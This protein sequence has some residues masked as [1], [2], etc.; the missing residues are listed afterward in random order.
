MTRHFLHC[1][2]LVVLGLLLVQCKASKNHIQSLGTGIS[3]Q[4]LTPHLYVHLSHI[5]LSNGNTFPCNGLIYINRGEAM[6]FDT[7]LDEASS[8]ALIAWLQE[9]KKVK[10]KGVVAN[11]FHEDCLGT[12]AVFHEAGIPS[13]ANSTTIDLAKAAGYTVPTNGFDQTIQLEVGGE[14]I[15]CWHPGEAHTV[16]N[17][18]AWIPK[19]K[20]LFGGCMLKSVGATKGNLADANVEAWSSTI[21]EVKNKYPNLKWAVPGHG[22]SGGM[23]LLDFTIQLFQP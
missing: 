1:C 10:I 3:I 21:Q 22:D 4:Q 13:Y 16:D 2:S 11:H 20:A 15:E 6:I 5:T 23:E 19:E 9:E 7:P 18:V 17:I 12:L 8:Q 14:W